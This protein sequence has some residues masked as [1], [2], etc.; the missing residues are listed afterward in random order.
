MLRQFCGSYCQFCALCRLRGSLCQFPGSHGFVQIIPW[1]SIGWENRNKYSVSFKQFLESVD[2]RQKQQGDPWNWQSK[3]KKAKWSM[4]LAKFANEK[5]KRF[6][7]L[8]ATCALQRE[9]ESATSVPTCSTSRALLIQH[10]CRLSGAAMER[11]NNSLLKSVKNESWN[12]ADNRNE[13]NWNSSGISNRKF[14]CL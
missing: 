9:Q 6:M 11:N 5:A 7:K 1:D 14:S 8:G 2:I 13:T 10:F 4:K 3:L 12:R